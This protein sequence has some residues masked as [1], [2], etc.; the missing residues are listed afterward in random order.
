MIT[1][2]LFDL[3]FED[4]LNLKVKVASLFPKSALEAAST[5]AVI[6]P[7]DWQRLGA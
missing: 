1:A 5:V 3:P 2:S 6:Q 4:V 7:A